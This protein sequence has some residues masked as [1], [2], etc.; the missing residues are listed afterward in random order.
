[1]II[2]KSVWEKSARAVFVLF[3]VGDP[4]VFVSREVFIPPEIHYLKLFTSV[5][6]VTAR[7][8]TLILAFFFVIQ[9]LFFKKPII[10]TPLYLPIFLL[11]IYQGISLFW[12]EN[13]YQGMEHWMRWGMLFLFFIVSFNQ[14][15]REDIPKYMALSTIP[16]FLI[17]LIGTVAY[18]F[19]L[20]F[21]F[22]KYRD[23]PWA[24]AFST[25]K[26]AGEYLLSF[27]FWTPA[28]Y[29]SGKEGKN[30]EYLKKIYLFLTLFFVFSLFIVFQSRSSLIALFALIPFLIFWRRDKLKYLFKKIRLLTLAM[31]LIII[32][33]VFLFV[34]YNRN[35]KSIF[36]TNFTGNTQRFVMW[37]NTVSMISDHPLLGVGIGNFNLIYH[38]YVTPEDRYRIPEDWNY[39]YVRQAH[40]EY[41][42][43]FSE[44][45]IIGIFLFFV[46]LGWIL[47]S[48]ISY[49]R[50]N[51][52]DA[53][54]SG[55]FLSFL[56]SLIIS[57]F[58]FN[59][60]TAP[61]S[62]FFVATIVFLLKWMKKDEENLKIKGISLG[63]PSASPRG[64]TLCRLLILF[65]FLGGTA[66]FLK[67]LVS[68]VFV[69]YYRRLGQSVLESSSSRKSDKRA[70]E[71]L[72]KGFSWN[73]NDWEI[74]YLIANAY[75]DRGLL[76][77]ALEHTKKSFELNPAHVLTLYNMGFYYEKTGDE[78][79]ALK[80]YEK[81]LK[82]NPDFRMA[83][84]RMGY[85]LLKEGKMI[86][87]NR[88]FKK[89]LLPAAYQE[90]EVAEALRGLVYCDL[91]VGKNK[92]AMSYLLETFLSEVANKKI[93]KD[94][95]LKE[96]AFTPLFQW[97]LTKQ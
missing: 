41:L 74:H 73:P 12:T 97:W 95:L 54:F 72:K 1:M 24:S 64:M 50:K 30:E 11:W 2:K 45:G 46:F 59:F 69:D 68:V 18:F 90:L 29:F 37:K 87:A 17:C 71:I 4:L 26:F 21:S 60:Q 16:A 89:T 9:I 10:K 78:E 53:I 75:G 32:S 94:Y 76:S 34:L 79:A 25:H 61:T 15:K 27:I 62:Y 92:R 23:F 19:P 91:K 63:D 93:E 44:L 38:H 80:I 66:L 88:Y 6:E 84:N 55:L 67:P 70:I 57:F 81:I 43:I 36:D 82:K 31:I 56:G 77:Q 14:I 3:L 51:K 47:K 28:L 86:E 40:N 22:F 7:L 48:S 96:K 13:P 5:K 83:S 49:L 33:G 35:I 42:Q 8:F 58:V 39:Y 85:L 52:D 65:L 20:D